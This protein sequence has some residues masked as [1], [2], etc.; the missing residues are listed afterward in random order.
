MSK[1]KVH[2]VAIVSLIAALFLTLAAAVGV[3]VADRVPAFAEVTPVE[4]APDAVFASGGVAGEVGA[5]E[6]EQSYVQFTFRDGGKVYFRR[7]LAYKWFTADTENTQSALA[8]PGKAN[9]FSMQFVLPSLTFETFTVTFESAEESVSEEKKA[10]NDIVFRV[11]EGTLQVAV[12]NADERD[13]EAEELAWQDLAGGENADVSIAFS[14]GAHV[15]EF[16]VTVTSGETSVSGVLTNIGGNYAEYR[17][18]SSS[19]PK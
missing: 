14:E 7:D 12:R 13:K 4:Y 16:A 18:S 6:G 2:F 8:N 1:V 9:Y 3:A 17:S 5:S 11:L 10:V 19:S 15:G